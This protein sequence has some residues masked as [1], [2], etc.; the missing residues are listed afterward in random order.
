MSLQN[1]LT[2][3]ELKVLEKLKKVSVGRVTTYS[4]LARAVNCPKASRAVGNAIHKNPWA[5]KVPCHRA[6]KSNGQVGGYAKGVRKKIETLEKEG[7][8]IKREKIIDFEKILFK[9]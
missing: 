7:I 8:V 6:V 4:E 1:K 9:F 3:F 5:P 2:D